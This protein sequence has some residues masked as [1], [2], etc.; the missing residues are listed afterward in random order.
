VI[1]GPAPGC[2]QVVIPPAPGTVVPAPGTEA[3]VPQTVPVEP[4]KEM[5]KTGGAKVG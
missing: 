2:G 3:P 4:K 5:P 1:A